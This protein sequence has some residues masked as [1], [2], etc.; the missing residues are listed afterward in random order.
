M[1]NNSLY[2][3]LFA[4]VV[5]ISLLLVFSPTYSADLRI[6]TI[7]E[8]PLNIVKNNKKEGI[9]V[10]VVNEIIR[11]TNTDAKIEF[12]PW[13]RAYSDLLNEKNVVLFS[14]S[15][16]NK[17]EHLLKWVGPIA[18]KNMVL[19]ARRDSNF[20][21]QSLNQAKSMP[22]ILTM[23]SDSKSQ[24]LTDKGFTNLVKLPTWE[25]ALLMLATKRGSLLTQS[26]IDF[27]VIAKEMN[28]DSN[29]FEPVFTLFSLETYIGMSNGTSDE[30]V[31]KWQKTLE[32]I[33][34]DGTFAKIVDKWSTYYN[35]K[36]WKINQGMLVSESTDS[37]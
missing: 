10:D 15:R 7:N 16:T 26:D 9:T 28:L 14:I 3:P 24:Y 31:G 5:A 20:N 25:Q 34:K 21:I 18:K 19:Y 17:R 4:K 23:R 32:E 8:P 36:Q 6:Y 12:R 1:K 33:K 27:P 13:P 35:V 29:D 2:R 30:V 22:S 11:R 37:N